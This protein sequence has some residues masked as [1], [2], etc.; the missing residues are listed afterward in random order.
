MSRASRADIGSTAEVPC[1]F[2]G[3]FLQ[4]MKAYLVP[5]TFQT[6]NRRYTTS[7]I[8]HLCSTNDCRGRC[9]Y[10][11]YTR[12]GS[13]ELL[14]KIHWMSGKV[15]DPTWSSLFERVACPTCR[16]LPLG[17]MIPDLQ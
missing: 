10:I 4:M 8:V 7:S 1:V 17:W 12:W 3:F 15:C 13:A 6:L 2:S 14:C 16:D 9:S 5:E 11:M